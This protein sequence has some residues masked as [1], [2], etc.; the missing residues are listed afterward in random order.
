MLN[1]I[2]YYS[3]FRINRSIAL[4]VLPRWARGPIGGQGARWGQGPPLLKERSGKINTKFGSEACLA[5]SSRKS[6]LRCCRMASM[7]SCIAPP[8]LPAATTRRPRRGH[9]A[10]NT[11]PRRGQFPAN[12]RPMPGQLA[13]NMHMALQP[14]MI[15]P[16]I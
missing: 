16:R 5:P 7:R 3:K 14:G 10:A 11:R 4:N 8:R 15:I 2:I 6:T 1:S 9:D 12:S 13:A